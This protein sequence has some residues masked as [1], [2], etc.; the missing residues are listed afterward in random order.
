MSVQATILMVKFVKQKF[1][2]LQ[3]QK[4][5][6]TIVCMVKGQREETFFGTLI[7]IKCNS[8]NDC[9]DN[10]DTPICDTV[11]GICT[12]AHTCQDDTPISGSDDWLSCYWG[13]T[14]TCDEFCCCEEGFEPDTDEGYC[15]ACPDDSVIAEATLDAYSVTQSISET[16][17]SLNAITL[18][19]AF[20]GLGSVLY[21]FYLSFVKVPDYKEV[22]DDIEPEL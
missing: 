5:K 18:M 8:D 1:V 12:W 15:M 4:T 3:V 14:Y 13:H 17:T 6:S 21:G 11:E 10:P 2:F 7:G 16:S 19:F 22:L 9:S 20:I